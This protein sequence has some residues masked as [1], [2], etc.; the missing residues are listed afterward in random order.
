MVHYFLCIDDVGEGNHLA[1]FDTCDSLD[2]GGVAVDGG[3]RSDSV[4]LIAPEGNNVVWL[5][6][7]HHQ[8]RHSWLLG[9]LH[10][11]AALAR[12]RLYVLD[13][14]RALEESHRQ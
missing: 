4:G 6:R 12:L 10:K 7:P 11:G 14:V 1:D 2:A 8:L 9:S 13:H 5:F 3:D